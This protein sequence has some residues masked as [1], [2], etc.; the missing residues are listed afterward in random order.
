LLYFAKPPLLVQRLLFGVLAAITRALGYR[1]SYPKYTGGPEPQSE[2]GV[3]P[4][5]A[6]RV[7]AGAFAV[8]AR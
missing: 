8:V 2:E 7:M 4:P 3:G 6:T 1:D 5:S